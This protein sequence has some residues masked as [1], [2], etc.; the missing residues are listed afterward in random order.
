M[1]KKRPDLLMYVMSQ[2]WRESLLEGGQA[3]RL[4]ALAA[5]HQCVGMLRRALWSL[6]DSAHAHQVHTHASGHTAGMLNLPP[7]PTCDM[8]AVRSHD[9]SGNDTSTSLRLQLALMT[10]MR[11]R[12][13]L[14]TKCIAMAFWG[15]NAA[16]RC[17]LRWRH[18]ITARRHKHQL[19]ARVIS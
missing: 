16:H 18:Y 11:V 9:V 15:G 5:E 8:V 10:K 17:F 3:R 1:S 4:Y 6:A 14:Q 13:T 12:W 19:L 2:R 7:A